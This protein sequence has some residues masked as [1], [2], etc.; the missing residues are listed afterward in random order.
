MKLHPEQLAHRWRHTS[1]DDSS[2]EPD[3]SSS[4]EPPVAVTAQNPVAA[5]RTCDI[6]GLAANMISSAERSQQGAR[7]VCAALARH[8]EK[9]NCAHKERELAVNTR[10]RQINDDRHLRAL[11]VTQKLF[12][13]LSRDTAGP[14]VPPQLPLAPHVANI[15][16]SIQAPTPKPYTQRRQRVTAPRLSRVN[17]HTFSYMRV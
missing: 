3:S 6:A 13:T 10:R 12:S 16:T 1:L 8:I 4:H 9:D 15:S 14:R 7:T 2:H 11:E 5:T 17:V